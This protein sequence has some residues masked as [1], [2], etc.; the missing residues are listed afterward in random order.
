M[1]VTLLWR[2][3]GQDCVPN[4][5]PHHCLLNCLFGHRSKKTSKLR[6]TGHWLGNSPG[7]GEFPAQ[8]A[9]NAENV[10]IWWRHHEIVWRRTTAVPPLAPHQQYVAGCHKYN[11]AQVIAGYHIEAETNGRH[12]ADDIF[13]CVFL[14]ENVWISIK[15]SLKFVPKGR[16]NNIPA[17][18]QIM[19][20][21]RPGDKP[22]SE[23]M[24]VSL[25]THICV[26]RPQWIIWH[27][28]LDSLRGYLRT[29]S[30]THISKPCNQLY[31]G[32]WGLA[33]SNL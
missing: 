5:Q 30:Y 9:S 26:T 24:I 22:L 20:W 4:H 23:P 10:S 28:N 13:R 11:T 15:L 1:H 3:N 8:M 29:R 14:N 25:P 18:V 21:C 32:L 17:L 7:T 27:L 2:Q 31:R 19:A 16:I 6:V 12:L 33:P